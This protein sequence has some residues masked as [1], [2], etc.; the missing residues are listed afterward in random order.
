MCITVAGIQH[1]HLASHFTSE[2]N[3]QRAAHCGAQKQKYKRAR[4]RN[5]EMRIRKK[6]GP[7]GQRPAVG[8]PGGCVFFFTVA[9]GEME[10]K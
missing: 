3:T 4:N 10:K 5:E 9:A 7:I 2:D 1:R 8:A 6:K